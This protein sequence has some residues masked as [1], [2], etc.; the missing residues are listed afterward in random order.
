MRLRTIAIIALSLIAA[1]LLIDLIFGI[2]TPTI[3][4]PPVVMTGDACKNSC[5]QYQVVCKKDRIYNELPG[6]SDPDNPN[7]NNTCECKRIG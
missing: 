1:V 5:I 3:G 4:D 2:S 6:C 7:F